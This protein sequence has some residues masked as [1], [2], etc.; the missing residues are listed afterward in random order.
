MSEANIFFLTLL[1]ALWATFALQKL[2][3][4]VTIFI[5]NNFIKNQS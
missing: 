3:N 4:R 2:F 5:F 1:N